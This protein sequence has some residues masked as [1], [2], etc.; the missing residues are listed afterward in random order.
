MHKLLLHCV[1][2]CAI[3]SLLLSAT[4]PWFQT[5]VAAWYDGEVT[6]QAQEPTITWYFRCAI[7]LIALVGIS[8]KLF[9]PMRSETSVLFPCLGLLVALSFPHAILALESPTTAR[10]A[11]LQ[12]QHA[13]N[14]TQRCRGSAAEQLPRSLVE[15][16]HCITILA[17]E[18]RHVVSK[19]QSNAA[20]KEKT[21]NASA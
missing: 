5:P 11:W 21:L 18:A 3:L 17:Y 9:A 10:A 19:L 13:A 6:I 8:R 4:M 1:A 12:I 20:K 16:Q 2:L 15:P 7:A 14:P